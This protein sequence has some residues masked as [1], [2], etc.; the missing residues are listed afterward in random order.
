MRGALPPPK[1]EAAWKAVEAQAGRLEAVEKVELKPAGETWVSLPTARFQ[2]AKL[3]VK[4]AY[5]ARDEI[6]GL[7][8]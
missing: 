2:K 4:V 8:F 5:D 1:F 6:V 3:I 7:F